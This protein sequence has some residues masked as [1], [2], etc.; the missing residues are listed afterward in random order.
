MD[1]L[2]HSVHFTDRALLIV[3]DSGL[4][5]RK[6]LLQST[7]Q[8]VPK[9][10]RTSF[11]EVVAVH[12]VNNTKQVF[13]PAYLRRGSLDPLWLTIASFVELVQVWGTI[14]DDYGPPERNP[15]FHEDPPT[16]ST[17]AS[18]DELKSFSSA[19]FHPLPAFPPKGAV[20]ADHLKK[21]RTSDIHPLPLFPPSRPSIPINQRAHT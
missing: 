7:A 12:Q 5:G 1:W 21:A 20:H 14:L 3:N 11:S 10:E 18:A 9:R 15:P 6:L 19:D 2:H 8:I 16:P 4:H 17:R 13:Y